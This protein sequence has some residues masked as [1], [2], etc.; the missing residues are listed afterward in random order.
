MV[1]PTGNISESDFSVIGYGAMGLSTFY[2]TLLPDDDR[3]NSLARWVHICAPDICA[4]DD[5]GLTSLPPLGLQA[6]DA[7]PESE[8]NHIDAADVDGESEELTGKWSVLQPAI[9]LPRAILFH[10]N[11]T[12][13]LQRSGYRTTSSSRRSSAWSSA[14]PSTSRRPSTGPRRSSRPTTLICGTWSGEHY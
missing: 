11:R 14:T 9:P 13:R 7:V 10:L 3:L 5:H 4:P 2:G 8:Y 6:L 12:S 1:A